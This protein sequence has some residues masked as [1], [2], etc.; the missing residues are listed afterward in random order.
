VRGVRMKTNAEEQIEKELKDLKQKLLS[1][2]TIIGAEQVLKA[3][4]SKGLSQVF[5]ASNCP[6]QIMNDI[7]YYA[8]L[9][10][11]SVS[12]LKLSNEELGV[13]CKKNFFV[14]VIGIRLE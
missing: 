5:L 3:L 6:A 1:G 9:S 7:S 12:L 10:K 4:K 2:K 13:F 8:K 14:S 11:V